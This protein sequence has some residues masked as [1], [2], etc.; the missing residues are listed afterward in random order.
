[1]HQPRPHGR[2]AVG[3]ELTDKDE[4]AVELL[5]RRLT[6]LRQLSGVESLRMV[7]T[8]PD[9]GYVI[10]QDMGGTFR[11]ITHKPAPPKEPEFDGIAVDYLPM[12]F[13]GVVTRA[14]L[15][16]NEGVK[17]TLSEGA[18]KRI[19]NYDPEQDVPKEV[20][21]QRFRIAYNIMV[22]ELEPKTDTNL[23]YSQYDAQRPTWY[24]GAMAEVM[25]IVGGYGRQRL[26]ELPDD[27]IERA[28]MAIPEPTMTEIK[29]QMGNIRLPGYTGLPNEDGQFQYDYKF[30]NTHGVGFGPDNKPWLIKVGMSGVF[31]MPLPLIPATTTPAFREYVEERGDEELVSILDRFG[32]MPS[33][34][35]FPIAGDG[36][37]VW[38]RAGVVIKICD[39]GDF[40]DHSAYSTACGWSFNSKGSEGYNTCYDHDETTGVGYGLAYK[41][42]I[43]LGEAAEDKLP[44]V[45]PPD[46]PE[47]VQKLNAYLAGLFQ[48]LGNDAKSLAIKYKL[49]RVGTQKILSVASTQVTQSDVDYWDNLQLDPLATHGGSVSQVSRGWL[50]HG[51]PFRNQPQ[52]KFPEPFFGGCISH[53][54]TAL[55]P[56]EPIDPPPNPKCDTIMFGYYIGDT[57]RVIKYFRDDRGLGSKTEDDFEECMIVGS[58]TMVETEAGKLAGH[59]YTTDIDERKTLP[60][61]I[62]TTKII[63]EDLG[64]DSKP[65]FAYDAWFW[66]PGTIWRNRYFSQQM[67][68]KR[69]EGH[70]MEVAVCI[71]Y[72]CRNAVLHAQ[73]EGHGGSE[74]TES[75]TLKSMRDPTSYRYWTYDFVLAWRGGI[76]GAKG[77]PY[78]K[79]GNPVWVEVE[80]YQPYPCSDFAD[81]GSWIQGLPADYTWLVHPD[82]NR[83]DFDGGGG[84]PSFNPTSS[85]S[86]G[87]GELTGNLKM[88]ILDDPPVSTVFN[89]QEP[90]I[91]YFIA[92]PDL[93][94]GVFYRDACRAV[95][96]NTTYANVSER[97]Q[98]N[99][100]YKHFGNS[101][102]VDHRSAHHFIGV[103]HE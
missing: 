32:G 79:D 87:E 8:L 1:M 43:K 45:E 36:M 96:G 24:S 22:Q 41:L 85:D 34:E 18:R 56:P 70:Y 44:P 99:G 65:F 93:F 100:P 91:A 97:E 9:G 4:A 83:W 80:Q 55:E 20:Q 30:H 38:K 21:L 62:T 3:G 95:F 26:K 69:T 77:D 86:T 57:L 54:F 84:P 78:P 28:R 51:A 60:D 76:P 72:F 88:S 52:I 82:I 63:G 47:E 61:T 37:E 92:S 68:E 98:T 13:S 46:D 19:G 66:R 42:T 75:S 2:L 50:F 58:W 40:Y 90:N 103:I 27:P 48:L 11:V 15:A 64:Y 7:R 5:A 31:A 6:N 89:D 23:F 74:E 71:P 33:G 73:K 12:L 102:L 35:G 16:G 49:R 29:R 67:T 10:A 59:F 101:S 39:T 53:D 14:A 94:L 17:I 81:S 25:Q